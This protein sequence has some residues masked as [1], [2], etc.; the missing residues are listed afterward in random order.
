MN[1]KEI[2]KPDYCGDEDSPILGCV[3]QPE[4]SNYC[5]RDLDKYCKKEEAKG[6]TFEEIK[7]NGELE[8]F[9]VK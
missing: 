9:R 3:N 1:D 5:I 8:Q 4:L 7:A 2:K 6:R